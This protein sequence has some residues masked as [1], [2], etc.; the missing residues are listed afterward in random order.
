MTKKSTRYSSRSRISDFFFVAI[1]LAVAGLAFADFWTHL[2]QS[3]TKS[4]GEQIATIT[5]KYNTAQRHFMDRV[6]WDRLRQNSPLY[7]GDTVRI[8]PKSE[9]TIHFLD[10]SGAVELAENTLAQ[11]NMKKEQGA[12]IKMDEGSLRVE[13]GDGKSLNVDSGGRN[14]H[15][16]GAASVG[17][18]K[19]SELNV[20]VEKGSASVG[21]DGQTQSIG[22][23]SAIFV[24]GAGE[25]G[26]PEFTVISP[27]RSSRIL[28]FSPDPVEINYSCSYNG[29][30]PVT[31]LLELADNQGFENAEKLE[32]A[33]LASISASVKPGFWYWRLSVKPKEGSADPKLSASGRFSVLYAPSPE[34][35]APIK[36]YVAR[37][38][39]KKPALRF[40]WTENEYAS[41]YQLE[42]AR[43]RN[44]SNP[45][46][47]QR[48]DFASSIISSLGEGTWYWRVRPYYSINNEGLAAASDISTFSIVKSGELAAPEMLLPVTDSIVD[49]TKKSSDGRNVL[50]FSWSNNTEAASYTIKVAKSASMSSPV[51]NE[52]TE[53]NYYFFS[54]PKGRLETGEWFWQVVITDVEGNT[55]NSEVRR[56]YAAE[57]AVEQRTL[58]PPEGYRLSQTFTPDT[59]YVWKSNVPAETRF[60]ISKS[61]SFDKCIVDEVVTASSFA[62][63]DLKAGTYYWRIYAKVGEKGMQTE[64]K[65]LIIEPP[66]DPPNCIAPA[67]AGRAVIRP[68]TPFHFVWEPVEG[69]DY[70]NLKFYSDVEGGKVLFEHNFITGTSIDIDLENAGERRYRW[71]L[72]AFR[73]ETPMASRATGYVGSYSFDLRKLR[74]VELMQPEDKA[75]IGGEDA[76]KKPGSIRWSSVD[77]PAESRFVL[78][79]DSVDE[80]NII[81]SVDKPKN[82]FK[83]P[84]LYE[85]TYYWTVSARTGDDLDI[86]AVA[87]HSFSVGAIPSLPAVQNA[88]PVNGM[89]VNKD[90]LIKSRTIVFSWD[91]VKGATQYVFRLV[92]AGESKPVIEKTLNAN[93]RTLEFKDLMLLAQ[94]QYEW[95]VEPQSTYEGSLFQRGELLRTRFSIDLPKV[96]APQLSVPGDLY[97]R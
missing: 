81:L 20:N 15:V 38:R 9:A 73:E 16:D 85:G 96:N 43:N 44:M 3:L 52:K 67:N 68:M 97:G 22:A 76:V 70:Y 80:K 61:T 11:F 24:S 26:K 64:P 84:K 47:V 58:F 48:T 33:D 14:I 37:F 36:D 60:Q 82:D 18:G 71:T 63:R 23:G 66:L 62:G 27:G 8:A 12:S 30:Q 32:F 51:V 46:V 95:T 28:D 41:S 90:Y 49:I 34:P 83:L 87:P 4:G 5:F 92:R 78:Y 31:G 69:A 25:V 55:A 40:I 1:C 79:K 91:A 59:K 77:V 7:N 42:I 72:Q 17:V 65:P 21:L 93:T 56:F 19:G 35:I 2:N 39:S 86:S 6:L 88:K 74:P 50:G 10:G 29:P 89:V 13:S 54:S 94:G 45:E 53:N 57:G 75:F